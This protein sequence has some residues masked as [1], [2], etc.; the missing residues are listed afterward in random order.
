MTWR[1]RLSLN[2]LTVEFAHTTLRRA[3]VQHHWNQWIESLP[4]ACLRLSLSTFPTCLFHFQFTNDR[5][6]T[7]SM[8]GPRL[9]LI[10]FP[11]R[12]HFGDVLGLLSASSGSTRICLLASMNSNDITFLPYFSE[13]L[14]SRCLSL[15][16]L[17]STLC[18]SPSYTLSPLELTPIVKKST[19]IRVHLSRFDS[20]DSSSQIFI[21][22]WSALQSTTSRFA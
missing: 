4:C 11:R 13:L 7:V 18:V 20:T 12:R 8:I 2:N 17:F 9:L 21:W 22:C 10:P 16:F 1:R 15:L 6:K 19:E 14:V 3:K 5:M